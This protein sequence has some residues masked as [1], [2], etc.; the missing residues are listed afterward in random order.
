MKSYF[1]YIIREFLIESWDGTSV[2]NLTG[3][4]SSIQ[5]FEDVFSPAIFISIVLVNTDG[6]L[7]SLINNDPSMKSG[8]K[9]GERVRLVIEQTATQKTITLDETKNPYYIYKIHAA[10]SESTREV[11]ILELAPSE[12]FANETSRVF[13][14]YPEQE[15]KVESI[16]TSVKLILKNVL[17]T[18]K[19][20][21]AESTLNSYS[22]FGNSKKPFT[23]LT[24]LC[25]KAIPNIG[26]SGS[27]AG[28]AGFLFYENKN[29]YNFKSVDNLLSGLKSNSADKKLIEKY[30]YTNAV[31]QVAD[32]AN[33]FRIISMPVFEKNVNIFENLR[34]GMYSSVNYFFDIN[35]R[36]I[37]VYNYKLSES[38]NIMKHSSSNNN[39]KPKI[40]KG[41]ENSPSRLMV[42]VTDGLVNNTISGNANSTPDNR[43][44]YQ[45]QSVARYNL[46]FAQLLNITI[47]LNLNLTVGDVIDLNFGKITKD[48]SKGTLDDLKSGYY[49]IKELSH[50]F[51]DSQGYTGLKLVR[52]SYG[53][54]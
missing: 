45:S 4:V 38:Y 14:R 5:Y 22:F 44:K 33:N 7:T 48:S 8:I 28:T 36:K 32:F 39:D 35:T 21:E 10:S 34:I 9:G 16:D 53:R 2:I 30:Y 47:P 31:D 41:L 27:E 54:S 29:G 12:V 49:L 40:P 17:K 51:S 13:K 42:K 50:L 24:W 25:P 18:S 26:K 19:L 6:L 43:I 37:N 20:I 52:D 11:F 23:I 1:N 15:G 46:A 3:C